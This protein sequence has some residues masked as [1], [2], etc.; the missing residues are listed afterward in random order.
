M[1]PG[2]LQTKLED[3]S[4][5]S[6]IVFSSL[7]PS[8]TPSFFPLSRTYLLQFKF[9][10]QENNRAQ[11]WK[12]TAIQIALD[13]KPAMPF[14]RP[15]AD[16][17]ACVLNRLSCLTLC[18]SIDC[19]PPGSSVCGIL[20][21]RILAMSSSRRSSRAKDQTHISLRLLNWQAGSLPLGPPGK[22]TRPC[23]IT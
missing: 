16:V 21:A 15:C 6:L 23:S 22:P 12:Y 5:L 1:I 19:S 20:Q 14:T 9:L 18:D 2:R 3:A 7:F 10:L 17:H 8:E 11:A 4:T 13:L